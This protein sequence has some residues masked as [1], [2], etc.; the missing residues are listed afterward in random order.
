MPDTSSII[1]DL[2]REPPQSAIGTNW[3]IFT[4]RVMGGLSQGSIVCMQYRVSKAHYNG[5][6]RNP[7]R[8]ELAIY[9][10]ADFEGCSPGRCGINKTQATMMVAMIA[11][12]SGRLKLSPPWLIGLSK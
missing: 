3:Q 4:D 2:S 12:A 6:L 10:V 9:E 7:R 5:S 1:D 8:H 11:V